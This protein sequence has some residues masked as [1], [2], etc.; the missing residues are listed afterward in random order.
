[1][2]HLANTFRIA[3]VALLTL[4]FAAAPTASRA[5]TASVRIEIVK[6]GF[7]VGA[8][9]GSG[10]MR[11]AGRNHRL[12]IG[13]LS[14]G[15]TIGASRALLVGRAYNM[16]RPSDIAGTYGQAEGGVTV[17]TGGKVA[18]LRNEKGVVLELRGHQVGLEFSLD[19]G[20]MVVT[21]R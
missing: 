20:G 17:V 7:I 13:G 8:Q 15:A 11:F 4:A 1:M 3:A 16:R 9:G 2:T 18:R 21:L 14:V 12:G 10:S 19:L 6:A 5:E